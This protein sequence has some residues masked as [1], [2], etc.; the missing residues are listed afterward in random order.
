[1]TVDSLVV[2]V[3]PESSKQIIFNVLNFPN[4]FSDRTFFTYQV[5]NES[6][7]LIDTKINIYTQEG[8]LLNSLTDSRTNNFVAI[9]WDGTDTNSNLFEVYLVL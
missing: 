3:I 5:N 1:M 4:P 8:K 2:N 9:E 7:T 6:N